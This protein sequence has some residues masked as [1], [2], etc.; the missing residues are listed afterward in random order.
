ME[1]THFWSPA[2][3]SATVCCT[4]VRW[5][6]GT[7]AERIQTNS[8]RPLGGS[9]Y[10]ISIW[11]L[12]RL[13]EMLS[14]HSRMWNAQYLSQEAEMEISSSP[15]TTKKTLYSLHTIPCEE[16]LCFPSLQVSL[17]LYI[18]QHSANCL[19]FTTPWQI[20]EN[21]HPSQYQKRCCFH[22]CW[23]VLLL[24]S[25]CSWNYQYKVPEQSSLQC[26]KDTGYTNNITQSFTCP[27]LMSSPEWCCSKITQAFFNNPQRPQERHN[28]ADS[29][30]GSNE[31]W[32]VKKPSFLSF[33]PN[34]ISF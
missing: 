28:K 29:T 10:I 5:D 13:S 2:G 17:C 9:M 25:I 33:H 7:T 12:C 1:D 11:K 21:R 6:S 23:D 8:L 34:K 3:C 30:V 18:P 4:Q 14:A 24:L 26:G 32:G 22:G 16:N 19:M 27:E 20:Q 31:E 15:R